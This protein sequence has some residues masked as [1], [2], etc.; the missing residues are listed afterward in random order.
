MPRLVIFFAVGLV[1][2]AAAEPSANRLSPAEVSA[3]AAEIV[4]TYADLGWF[5]G[6]AQ[7]QPIYE[8][9]IGLAD[10]E[11]GIPNHHDTL[12]NLGSIMKHY[13][14]VLVLQQVVAGRLDL[15]DRLSEFNIGFDRGPASRITVRQLLH[16]QSGFS[17]AFPASYRANPLSYDS[18]ESKLALLQDAPLRFEPGTDTRYSNYGY[19]VLGAILE[20]VTEKPFEDLLHDNIFRRLGLTHAHYPYNPGAPNQSLRY[21]FNYEGRQVLAGATEHHSPDGGIEASATDTLSFY[22][23]LFHSDT[24]LPRDSAITRSYFDPGGGE[25][26]QAFGGGV[27]VSSAVELDFK[28]GYEIVVLANTDQLVAEKM[29]GRIREAIATGSYSP[30]LLP[31][32][33]YAWRQFEALGAAAFTKS[34]RSHYEAAGYQQFVGRTL[35]EL[36]MS[37]LDA[38]AWQ[39]ALDILGALQAYFPE[40]PEVYDSLAHAHVRMGDLPGA[41]RHFREALRLD[42]DFRSDYSTSNYS[43]RHEE[44]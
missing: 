18:I 30:V 42:P 25:I 39:D 32:Q 29:S 15:N 2:A 22:R 23:A 43:I 7:G 26:W 21:V 24:L 17:G 14:A 5:S 41:A 31:P 44:D 13:T 34:F 8:T 16:H 4:S 28:H 1:A 27:G 12:Y 6:T 36:G 3:A 19:I 38:E 11:R 10:R 35:N 9:A 33:I 37:L 40:A 20:S